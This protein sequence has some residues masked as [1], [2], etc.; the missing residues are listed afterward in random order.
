MRHTTVQI[1]D[2]DMERLSQKTDN[3]VTSLGD[4]PVSA[5]VTASTISPIPDQTGHHN[6]H[7][8]IQN[9][10]GDSRR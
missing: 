8:D 5:T 7:R 10:T 1:A 3:P 2:Y 6:H 9:M 4:P